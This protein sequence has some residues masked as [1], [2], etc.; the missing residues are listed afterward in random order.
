M[1]TLLPPLKMETAVSSGE[2]LIY[3]VRD[4]SDSGDEDERSNGVEDKRVLLEIQEF[5]GVLAQ[6][7]RESSVLT[8]VMRDAFDGR[9]LSTPNK[10]NPCRATGA[11]FV[12][13][14]HITREEYTKLATATDISNGFS[15]RFM[16]VYSAR[17][18]RVP[19]PLPTPA[20]VVEHLA[21]KIASAVHAVI[22]NEHRAI[23]KTAL[24]R[25]RWLEIAAELDEKIRP[26]E[27]QKLMTRAPL[28]VQMLAGAIALLN[29]E[30]EI[31][32]RHLNAALA[33]VEYWEETAGF[34]FT[35]AKKVDEMH[36]TKMVCDE[37]VSA[38]RELGGTNVKH[39]V[40]AARVS[41]NGKRKDRGADVIRGAVRALQNEA[42]PRIRIG[43]VAS[44][45][46]PA[47]VYSIAE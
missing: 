18:K 43:T 21:G 25:Q 30:H 3:M 11:H 38:V 33:W 42:P 14:G 44:M 40:V 31:C 47:T 10:N 1:L 16:M 32:A 27:V 22:Q 15:N 9:P 46:R 29:C 24:G 6:T 5:S 28:Y 41:N 17:L 45:G 2:G 37:F 8:A 39:S 36:L 12:V 35:T 26:G 13:I 20:E 34:C 7:K 23:P 4:P 19:E